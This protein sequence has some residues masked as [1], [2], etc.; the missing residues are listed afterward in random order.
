MGFKQLHPI[1]RAIRRKLRQHRG[2]VERPEKNE[3]ELRLSSIGRSVIVL[4]QVKD[5]PADFY[6]LSTKRFRLF[7][8]LTAEVLDPELRPLHPSTSAISFDAGELNIMFT[9]SS[10]YSPDTTLYVGHD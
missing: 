4:V 7:L 10:V 8:S 2:S 3:K 5:P 6:F 1:E 9:R